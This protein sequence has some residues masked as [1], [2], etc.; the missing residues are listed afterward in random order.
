MHK[1]M[2]LLVLSLLAVA[3]MGATIYKWVDEK[4]VTHYSEAKPPKEKVQE[5]QVQPTP[6]A[7]TESGKPAAKSWQEQEL[8]FLK[9]H[10]ERQEAAKRQEEKGEA[11]KRE[12][13][14]RKQRCILARQNLHTLQMERAVYSINEKGERVFLDDEARAA[15][16]QRMKK[17]IE[18][19]CEMQ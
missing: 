13:L 10:T 15:E 18:S 16:S 4:G 1:K 14:V 5:I 8:E 12:A 6:P 7:G 11:A 2:P 9:R 19:F 3:T 17:E